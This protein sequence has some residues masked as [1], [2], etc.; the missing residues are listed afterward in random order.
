MNDHN[1]GIGVTEKLNLRA[2]VG[3][4]VK[5]LFANP[6]NEQTMLALERIAALRKIKEKSEIVVKAKPF[7]GAVRITNPQALKEYIGDFNF[8]SERSRQE[9]DLRILVH[10]AS[11]GK[12]KEICKEHLQDTKKRIID[13]SPDR[14]LTE[15]FEDSLKIKITPNEYK[16]KSKGMIIEELPTETDNVRAEGIPTVRIYFLYEAEIIS[17]D[18]IR[19]ML[20]NSSQYSDDD[21]KKIATEDANQDGKGR[22]NAILTLGHDELTDKYNSVPLERLSESVYFG[23]HFLDGNVPAILEEIKHPKYNRSQ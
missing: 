13:I 17:S 11:W 14:E 2:S 7:G 20:T 23:G 22:A 4:L 16:L 9:E 1:I 12:I 5:V 8:D 15:E 6:E 18:T 3:A 10:P 21:L 19:M